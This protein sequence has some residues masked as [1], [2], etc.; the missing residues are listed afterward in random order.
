MPFKGIKVLEMGQFIFI[1]YCGVHLA[2]FGADVIKVEDPAGGDTMRAAGA[3]HL[4]VVDFNYTFENNNRNKKS[5]AV[6]SNT[7]EGQ[8]IL[9]KLVAGMDV[10]T[11]NYRAKALK[12]MRMDYETLHKINPRLIYAWGTGW[13]INGPNK[14]EG[15]FDYS[16][17]AA[18]GL[19]STMG[20]DGSPKVQCE[21]GF[22]DHI[23]AM[24]MSFAIASALFHREK[25][26]EGQLVSVSLWGSL[27]DMGGLSL[28]AAIATGKEVP[29][30]T[31]FVTSNPLCNDY[32]TKDGLWFQI[33]SKQSDRNWPD[34][35]KALG[36]PEWEKDPRFNSHAKR[37]QNCKE[38][39][40]LLDAAFAT[41]TMAEWKQILKGYNV[42][43]SP[44][45]TYLEISSDPQ[46][47]ANGYIVET[48]HRTQ[49]RIN[50]TGEPV[51]MSKT[52]PK[53]ISGTPELGEHT[54]EI[55][56]D[57]GFGW[58]DIA[59]FKEKKAIL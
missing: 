36:K 8:A 6:D 13:G 23:S 43:W 54:E 45:R 10:F 48:E 44:V 18:S 38:L 20:E 52:P 12:K 17:W 28:H 19:M 37:Q 5:L 55:L 29:R 49:G 42:H 34:V 21:P 7:E 9:H 16:A 56:L 1:P 41:R 11:T 40:L 57:L 25:T 59:N 47:F 15:A 27:L 26:G 33:A 14:D 51:H 39:I 35:C 50:V 30:K 22:G 53:I 32:E 3:A 31:R 2:D 46:A 4:P 24:T 58:E